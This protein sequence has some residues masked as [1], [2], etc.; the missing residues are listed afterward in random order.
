MS[1]EEAGTKV[2]AEWEEDVPL[3]LI[4]KL[5]DTREG[6]STK[7][8][9][10]ALLEEVLGDDGIPLTE[11]PKEIQFIVG[12]RVEARY[13]GRAKKFYKG[14]IVAITDEKYSIDYVTVTKTRVYPPSS[15]D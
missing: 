13:R 10:D 14:T 11:V 9:V 5:E 3:S 6:D 2:E 7:A 4:H 15:S 1:V 12:D 8:D